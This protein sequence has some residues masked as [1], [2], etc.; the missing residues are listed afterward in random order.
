MA[1]ENKAGI[2]IV[3]HDPTLPSHHVGWEV[4]LS[5]GETVREQLGRDDAWRLLK[6]RCDAEDLL[7]KDLRYFGKSIHTEKKNEA[8][9]VFG[10]DWGV[11]GIGVVK[12]RVGVACVYY[13]GQKVRVH[14]FRRG[15]DELEYAEAR[16]ID[17][18]PQAHEIAIDRCGEV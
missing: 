7:I 6:H 18:F 8:Y 5:N 14:W 15:T 12:R 10:E 17:A 11:R 4:E 9:F 16:P 13:N 3:D 2:R 1:T